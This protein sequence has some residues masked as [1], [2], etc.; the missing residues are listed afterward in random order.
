MA[1]LAP[2]ND[3]QKR[4]I[5]EVLELGETLFDML[6]EEACL[7]N[8][9]TGAITETESLPLDDAR[10]AAQGLFSALRLLL[11]LPENPN[12]VPSVDTGGDRSVAQ[13]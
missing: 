5:S 4:V 7:G 1:T 2:Q 6:V 9:N 11:G 8:R 3:D 13:T 10:A 12:D